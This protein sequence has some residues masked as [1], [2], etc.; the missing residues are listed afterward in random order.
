MISQD[1]R[2]I[3][4]S[5]LRK[6]TSNTEFYVRI[7]EILDNDPYFMPGHLEMLW[8]A[9]ERHDMYLYRNILN[10][11]LRAI[12][13]I[14]GSNTLRQ[15]LAERW[16]KLEC[17]ALV[18]LIEVARDQ[19]GH[20]SSRKAKLLVQSFFADALIDVKTIESPREP[21]HMKMIETVDITKL[22]EE[23]RNLANY[24]WQMDTA[25]REKIS[26][27]QDTW[28]FAIRKLSKNTVAY[29][30]QDGVH[31][32]IVTPYGE[33]L[34]EIHST[35]LDFAQRHSLGLGRVAVVSMQPWA[36]AYR[37]YDSEEHL[38][39]RDRYH[40]VLQAGKRNVLSAGDESV[41]ARPGEIWFF[42]NKVMHRAY[43][44]SRIPRVHV[45]FDGYPLGGIDSTL[46]N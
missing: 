7:A 45:I 43:N 37:H 28:A 29:N 15:V 36:Q 41:I 1:S 30:P 40:L 23:L 33:R 19:K 10:D 18:Q 13:S 39:G 8:N 24:W 14:F 16:S 26:H 2:H 34:K 38:V 32:S 27:H 9:E 4:N 21:R 42:D 35:V 20:S 5:Y 22:S 6:A 44:Q 3:Y 25:R 46:H 31:E 12:D 11:A 17:D